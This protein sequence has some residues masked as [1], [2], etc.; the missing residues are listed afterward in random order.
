MSR[1]CRLEALCNPALYNIEEDSFVLGYLSINDLA[2]LDDSA[3]ADNGDT[4][5]SDST[6]AS[7]DP[8]DDPSDDS[9]SSDS[10]EDLSVVQGVVPYFGDKEQLYAFKHDMKMTA[11]L[12]IAYDEPEFFVVSVSLLKQWFS[13]MIEHYVSRTL[14]TNSPMAQILAE[15]CVYEVVNC[16]GRPVVLPNG[17]T[18]HACEYNTATFAPL[19]DTEEEESEMLDTEEKSETTTVSLSKPRTLAPFTFVCDKCLKAGS[20][21]PKDRDFL[22]RNAEMPDGG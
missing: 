13:V 1:R 20:Q 14:S 15:M 21:G 16:T 3:T 7:E 5:L 18:V 2:V 4:D 19:L 17:T 22:K 10:S 11:I 9:S 8:S 12:E 6:S